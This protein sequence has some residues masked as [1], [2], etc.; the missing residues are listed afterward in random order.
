[1]LRRPSRGRKA[2]GSPLGVQTQR[3]HPFGRPEVIGR[4][5]PA[6]EPR[7]TPTPG[8]RESEERLRHNGSPPARPRCPREMGLALPRV[9]R[10]RIARPGA[11]L[12]RSEGSLGESSGLSPGLGDSPFPVGRALPATLKIEG[13]RF[14]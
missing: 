14:L 8:L 12:A 5:G 4:V 1:V 10:R 13:L 9:P 2:E 11:R 3:E 6:F 7:R